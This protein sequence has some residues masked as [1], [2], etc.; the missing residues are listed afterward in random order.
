MNAIAARAIEA[1]DF[2][3]DEDRLKILNG[4]VYRF[5]ARL[6]DKVAP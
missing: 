3:T 1:M 2:L 5:F 6:K 4:N